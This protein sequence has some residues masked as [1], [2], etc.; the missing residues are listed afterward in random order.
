MRAYRVFNFAAGVAFATLS[1][2]AL[3]ARNVLLVILDDIG[4]QEIRSFARDLASAAKSSNGSSSIVDADG[5][6]LPDGL[7]DDNGD[8]APDGAIATPSIDSLATAGVRFTQV[9][10]NPV[11]SPT[12]AGI[13]TGRY[14]SHHGIGAP[15]GGAS[16]IWTIPKDIPTLAEVLKTSGSKYKKGLFGKWHLGDSTGMLPTD[17]G[18]DYFAGLTGGQVTS[19]YSW[20]KVVVS[21]GVKT[22]SK[23]TEYVTS[24]TTNDAIDWINDQTGSWW[25]TVAMNAAH[26]PYS[27]PP[28][29]CLSGKVTGTSDTALFHKTL[30]CADFHLGALIANI[31]PTVLANTT[32]VFVGDNGTEGDVSQVYESDRSKTSVY[33]GGVHVPMIVADGAALAGMSGTGTG[34]VTSVGRSVSH[35]LSTVDIFSTLAE[36]MGV[37][38]TGTDAVSFVDELNSTTAAA[39]RKYV[40]TDA[41]SYTAASVTSLKKS[42]SN[43]ASLKT[44]DLTKL[45]R[46]N[47]KGAIRGNRYKLVYGA[48][49]YKLFDLTNDPFEQHDKWCG[50]TSERTQAQTLITQLRLIDSTYPTKKCN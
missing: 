41:F 21:G 13:Y 35:P 38:A 15:L 17:R 31:E 44:S 12:R 43:P 39:P 20:D 47:L 36:I 27:E 9:T 33:Q 40:Y 25:A 5:N 28:S 7:E 46:T 26:T 4:A 10:S 1:T 32:I 16:M 8:G 6:G 23:V 48:S 11:C 19:Y 42:L 2:N 18:W 22:S 3:A 29:Y 50:T 14:G 30:E 24:E 37:S 49:A 45:T 34:A